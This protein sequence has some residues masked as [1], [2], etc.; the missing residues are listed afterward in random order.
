MPDC[1]YCDRSFDS[2]D[3]YHDHLAT[4]H[5]GELSRIDRRRIDGAEGDDDGGFP[6]GPVVLVGVIG[7]ALAVVLYVVFVFG[8]GGTSD[9]SSLPDRGDQ[10]V[11]SQVTTEPSTGRDHVS[12]GTD[13]D[14][15]G[16]PPTS[17]THYTS[18][19]DAGFYE[20]EQPLGAL[21]HTLE[22][23]AIIVYYDPG[24]L[25]SEAESDLRSYTE[26]LTGPWQSFVAVPNPNPN[27][28]AAYVLTAWEKRLT[29]DQYD[30]DA[31]RAFTAEY[32]G[33]GPE[34][35]VR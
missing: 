29:M 15:E 35:A 33:R 13:L 27:P 25:S 12:P 11:I 20:D 34:N 26:S 31:V 22:H 21:L 30:G 14:Y 16:A 19:V 9:T 17:G 3:E 5:G 10:A 28:E 24:R 18:T 2:D 23:G 32:L 6:T 8:G 1:K 7:F 4:E